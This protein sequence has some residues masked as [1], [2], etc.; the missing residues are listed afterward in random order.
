MN[1]YYVERRG[2]YRQGVLGV[3]DVLEDAVQCAERATHKDRTVKREGYGS[4]PDGYHDFVI[5]RAE[6][7]VDA[8]GVDVAEWAS[9]NKGERASYYWKGGPPLTFPPPPSTL[10]P[11]PTGT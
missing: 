4:D 10:P 9:N 1:V 5:V 11:S 3:F 6:I 8:D 7:G 2:V